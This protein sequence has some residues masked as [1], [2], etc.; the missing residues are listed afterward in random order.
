LSE[1]ALTPQLEVDATLKPSDISLTTVDTLDKL[2]PFGAKN[3]LPRFVARDCRIADARAIGRGAHLKLSVD[4]GADLCDAIW[5][6]QG[7]L[8]YEL[9]VGDRVDLAFA[10]QANTWQGRTNVQMLVEDMRLSNSD[11]G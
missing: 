10:L 6:R 8:V 4:T 3:E 1:E 2:A 11:K 9:S 5:F 7:E